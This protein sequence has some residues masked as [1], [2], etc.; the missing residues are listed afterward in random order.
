LKDK[1]NKKKKKKKKEREINFSN[2]SLTKRLPNRVVEKTGMYVI[3]VQCHCTHAGSKSVPLSAVAT[4][5]MHPGTAD[6]H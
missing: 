2:I 4:D 1:K 5:Y 3:H 6:Y